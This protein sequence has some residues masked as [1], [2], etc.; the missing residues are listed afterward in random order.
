MTDYRSW[1]VTDLKAELKRRGIP[2]TGLRVKQNFIDRLL[3]ADGKQEGGAPNGESAKSQDAPENIK[4]ATPE[5]PAQ[6][7]EADVSQPEEPKPQVTA[8]ESEEPKEDNEVKRSPEQPA[9]EPEAVIPHPEE[10][11]PQGTA[12]ESK[13]SKEGGEGKRL[14]EKEQ[15]V[16]QSDVQTEQPKP[17][18]REE[19]STTD[20]KAEE[21]AEESLQQTQPETSSKESE[22]D[23][24]ADAGAGGES[25][26][27]SLAPP[28]PEAE[29]PV[30]PVEQAPG[31]AEPV[32]PTTAGP[33]SKELDSAEKTATQVS[34]ETTGLS[35]P[36]PVEEM[37]EDTRKR[38]RRSQTPIPTT[39]AVASK[40]AKA[41]EVSPRVLLPEDRDV[42]DVEESPGKKAAAVPEENE[43]A[44]NQ[45]GDERNAYA[46]RRVSI[47][48]DVRTKG[49]APIKQDARFKD[50]FAPADRE[51]IRP[52]S[53][54]ADTEM[55]DAEVEP[56]LHVATEALYV[57]G[58]MRPLQPATL[59]NHLISIATAP[60]SSPD[61]DVI[62]DF[63]LDPIKTHCFVKFANISA[64]SRARTS[65]HGVVWPNESNRKALFVDFIPEQ[66]L[67]QW[68]AREEESR[69]RRGPP[70]RWEVRY[71]RTDDGVEAVLQEVDPKG[72]ASRQAPGRASTDFSRPLPWVP[73]QAWAIRTDVLAALLPQSLVLDQGKDSSHWMIS[74]NPL[75]LN[76]SS[77]TSVSLAKWPTDV[78]IGS[79]TC[80]GRDRFRGVVAMRIGES[81]LKT[82]TSSLTMD[83]SM[84]AVA[85]DGAVAGVV[86]A[87]WRTHGEMPDEAV[88]NDQRSLTAVRL[89]D[90]ILYYL[91]STSPQ[92][93]HFVGLG[94]QL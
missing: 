36:L 87:A 68:V 72:V 78:W 73:E 88:T 93:C 40:R 22:F 7:P 56:A 91:P 39:E 74:L 19:G 34:A 80:C 5:Q 3:E 15:K 42:M 30:K 10:P 12:A 45:N 11:K 25:S 26:A 59:K 83:R 81:L 89:K 60:G 23:Q 14:P 79:T 54:P 64:A 37:I 76:Q 92:K 8:P 90:K 63:Y 65:L 75:R 58:L 77:T 57:D 85:T 53:P 33:D 35:T 13:E 43:R 1:K 27:P 29:H 38:K 16:Q 62:V 50:L 49:T 44:H 86:E 55:E 61:P 47:S 18:P 84:E 48:D 32:Q 2:Q 6:E 94:T 28:Q 71:D 24:A 66:K 52:P 21:Q 4:Q 82:V 31:S 70:P 67:Q 9:Q 46:T 20:T 51:Q 69:G 17:E 41:Q